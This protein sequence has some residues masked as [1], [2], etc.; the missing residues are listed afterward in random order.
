MKLFGGIKDIANNIV[1]ATK[2]KEFKDFKDKSLEIWIGTIGGPVSEQ[3]I[4]AG[5]FII[6]VSDIIFWDKM[7]R[8]LLGTYIDYEAQ[9]NMSAKFSRDNEDWIDFTK[10]QIHILN[11]IDDDIKIDYYANCTRAFLL[12][13]IDKPLYFKLATILKS[14]VREDLDYLAKNIDNKGQLPYN[15]YSLSLTQHGLVSVS[16]SSGYGGTGKRHQN[17]TPL[18]ECVD[19]FAINFGSDRYTYGCLTELE[20]I[21]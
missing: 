12:E 6:S 9:I 20:K 14:T 17:F 19:K 15:I 7:K 11:E 21:L 1:I 3:F 13:M 4:E 18:A 2:S 5:K 8:F 10:R 16:Y